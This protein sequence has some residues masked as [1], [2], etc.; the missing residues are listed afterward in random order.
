MTTC[1]CLGLPEWSIFFIYLSLPFLSPF[2]FIWMNW[3]DNTVLI[4]NCSLISSSSKE[5]RQE[6]FFRRSNLEQTQTKG[7]IS[8]K[9]SL[10]LIETAIKLTLVVFSNV[11]TQLPWSI[12]STVPLL[13]P[14]A[15]I[16]RDRSAERDSVARWPVK[17]KWVH[18]SFSSFGWKYFRKWLIVGWL[19]VLAG[20]HRRPW[21]AKAAD[22]T[23]KSCV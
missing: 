22:L 19:S 12:I 2:L 17:T 4:E 7:T 23:K 10:L 8:V 16:L 18:F 15:L 14:G 9:I 20:T 1:F 13:S 3:Q 11:F 6:C 5:T 21:M